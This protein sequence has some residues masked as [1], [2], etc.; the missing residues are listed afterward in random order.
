MQ[1]QIEELLQKGWVEPSTSPYGAPIL[2]VGKKDGGLRMC[3]DYRALNKLTVKNRYPLPRI[4]DLFDQLRGAQYFSSIDLAQGYH[5]IRIPPEDVP[6]TAFRTPIGHF[7]F[8]V[9][10]FGLTNAPATFQQVMNQIFRHQVGKFVLVYL[11][12]ILIFSKTREEHLQHL[13]AVLQV[14]KQ[15]QF[16]A[17]LHKCFFLQ[18]E[19][20]YLGHIVGNGGIKPDPRKAKAVNDRP[21]PTNLHEL[22]QFPGLAN[23][24]R[25]YMAGYSI[26]GGSTRRL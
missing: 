14:L 22:R 16:Y 6:K 13:D 12:D 1:R 4:D 3:I 21:V 15:H 11:D 10:C 25:K 8:K 7:Q 26:S 19:I 23:Y 18:R 24:F 2:F 5:Q 17:R 9:L 20:E